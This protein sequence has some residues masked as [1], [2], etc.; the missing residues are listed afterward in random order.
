[1]NRPRTL[2]AERSGQSAPEADEAIALH[3][4]AMDSLSYIR[5]TM[6]RA[7]SFT[8]LSGWGFVAVGSTALVAAPVAAAQPTRALWLTTWLIAAIAAVLVAGGTT[9]RKARVAGEPLLGGPGRKL[10]LSFAPPAAVAAL[11]TPVLVGAELTTMLPAL[12]LLLY[13]A[14]VIT[15]GT[16]SVRA[17][18]VMGVSFM[19]LGAAA[20]VSPASWGDVW[21]GAGF[22]VL[23]IVF[24]VLIAR[25]HGG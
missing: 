7:G 5:R 22:G 23:H 17:V 19:A 16:F 18:P 2:R 4:H 21:M 24:G 1:M 14:A 20:L 15:G 3:A 9:L 11:L 8:A 13:G 6:E 25:R 10:V 12:W